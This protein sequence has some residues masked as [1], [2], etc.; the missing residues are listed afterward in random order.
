ML[1]LA[2]AALF[3]IQLSACAP[4]ASEFGQVPCDEVGGDVVE[5]L[6]SG[7]RV[8]VDLSDAKCFRLFPLWLEGIDL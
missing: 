7:E 2:V 5:I 4:Q 6:P 8:Q 3:S 1:L